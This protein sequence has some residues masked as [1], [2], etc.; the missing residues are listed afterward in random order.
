VFLSRIL[1]WGIEG[2]AATGGEPGLRATSPEVDA[3]AIPPGSTDK[4]VFLSRILNWGI[5]GGAATAASPA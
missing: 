1:N 4:S 3:K 5:E 2:G